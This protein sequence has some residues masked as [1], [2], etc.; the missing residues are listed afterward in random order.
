MDKLISANSVSDAL[1]QITI[2]YQTTYNFNAVKAIE[3][4]KQELDSIVAEWLA[5]YG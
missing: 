2:Y 5:T 1:R 3:R 4:I